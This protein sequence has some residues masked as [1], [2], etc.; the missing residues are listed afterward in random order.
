MCLFN[1]SGARRPGSAPN[2]G[3]GATMLAVEG[4]GRQQPVLAMRCR[5]VSIGLS[6]A[7]RAACCEERLVT[8]DDPSA[9]LS[10][11]SMLWSRDDRL[12]IVVHSE[13]APSD[14]EWDAHLADLTQGDMLADLKVIVYSL[15]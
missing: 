13:A 3:G 9:Q 4:K 8:V 5:R 10:M 11:K 15:G 1:E 7:H 14:R 2:V 12:A 6:V